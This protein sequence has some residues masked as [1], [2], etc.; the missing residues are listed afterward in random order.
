MAE[1]ISM[2]YIC[3]HIYVYISKFGC[4]NIYVYI[5]IA[6]TYMQ[7]YICVRIRTLAFHFRQQRHKH[8][9]HIQSWYMY[10][11]ILLADIRMHIYMCMCRY[12]YISAFRSLQQHNA[13]H[14][15]SGITWCVP[16]LVLESP[17]PFLYIYQRFIS[18]CPIPSNSLHNS[19]TYTW[20]L[21][22]RFCQWRQNAQCHTSRCSLI[23]NTTN[24]RIPSHTFLY[25]VS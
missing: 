8:L 4:T 1:C 14:H 19:C 23:L 25:S 15:T 18:P 10:I 3:K 7:I 5:W 22:L 9:R 24:T 13:Q 6:H 12:I 21:A 11:R 16:L 17:Q 2:Q 20:T